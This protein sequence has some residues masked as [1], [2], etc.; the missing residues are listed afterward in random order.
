MGIVTGRAYDLRP[1]VPVTGVWQ[2]EEL[3][4]AGN[5]RIGPHS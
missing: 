4:A 3:R 2:W 1:Y 5:I